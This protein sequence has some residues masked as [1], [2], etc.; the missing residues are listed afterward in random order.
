MSVSPGI[1]FAF[2]FNKSFS[3]EYK[4]KFQRSFFI[5]VLIYVFSLTSGGFL[6]RVLIEQGGLPPIFA[7]IPVFAYTTTVNFLGIKVFA[8]KNKRW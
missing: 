2:Y 4:E 6:L 3:F 5:Y 1:L 8:F 7:I